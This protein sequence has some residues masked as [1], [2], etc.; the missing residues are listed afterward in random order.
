MRL[1]LL[2]I[3]AA[4]LT[5]CGGG[6]STP[7]PAPATYSVG[8]SISGLEASGLVLANG[9]ATVRA[10]PGDTR[11]AFAPNV[12]SGTPYS[13]SIATQPLGFQLCNFSGPV[14]GAVAGADVTLAL[15]CANALGLVST[16]AGTDGTI[17]GWVDPYTS[18]AFSNPYHIAVDAAGTL[19][20]ADNGNSSIRK[21]SGGVVTTLAGGKRGAA[22]GIGIN[23]QFGSP[24]GVALD[25]AGNL[26]VTDGNNLNIRKIAPNGTV[27]TVAGNGDYG[28]ANGSA[29]T[30]SFTSPSGI[31]VDKAG[32]LYVADFYDNRI[33]KITPAGQVSTFAGSGSMGVVDGQGEAASFSYPAGLCIDDKGNLYVTDSAGNRV[34]KI[35]PS[36]AVTTLAGTGVFGGKADGPV[37][38][39]TFSQPVG[40][41]VDNAGF[42]YVADMGNNVVRKLSPS[43]QVST[44]AGGGL[45][46]KTDGLGSIA[47]FAS[48]KGIAVDNRGNLFVGDGTRVRKLTPAVGQ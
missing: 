26:F 1:P 42:I 8:G 45:S 6:S 27:T 39:A 38:T 9:S 2:A 28:H 36:G 41:A 33:R 34:R 29:S 17:G 44:L 35:T 16:V 11:F 12:T 4:L 46:Y 14:S 30:A 25:D 37:A 15:I 13:M 31:A 23:A 18:S 47:S 40:I 10:M 5:A 48:V 7:A 19:Y 32:N 22:D 24:V 20:V 3:S 43:G 21:I